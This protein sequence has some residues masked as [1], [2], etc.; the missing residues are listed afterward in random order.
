MHRRDQLAGLSGRVLE[1]GAGNGMNFQHY[2][3]TVSEVV[4][5]E[6]E[7]YLRRK[8]EQAP[9]RAPVPVAVRDGLAVHLL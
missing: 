4:A 6:P 7:P 9:R 1:L 5:V 8:A 2:P 3:A